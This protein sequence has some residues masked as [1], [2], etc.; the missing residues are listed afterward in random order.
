MREF[1]VRRPRAP[2][3]VLPKISF[4]PY[5][6]LEAVPWLML[7]SA[8]RFVAFG[9]PA[10]ALPCYILSNLAIF[11]AFL[12][13]ARRMIE[14]AEGATQLG[15]LAFNDQLRLGGKILGRVVLLLIGGAMVVAVTGPRELAIHMLIGFDGIAFD[16]FSKLGMLWS[17]FL[18][19][20]VLLMVLHAD[21]GGAVSFRQALSAFYRH[22]LY[23]VPAILLITAIAAG[24]SEVQGAL[25]GLVRTFDNTSTAPRQ[26]KNLV[27]F[28]FV[29]GFASLRLW[30][31]LAV[32][33]FALRESYR[34]TP[35]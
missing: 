13:A 4:G 24:V 27:Y 5:G 30:L 32:L 6:L 31:T 18:A 23:L 29:F 25:R 12:L 11:L 14:I 17:A 15:R 26:V 35:A 33:V 3:R 1:A 28:F 7:A 10:L 8:M 9:Q 19:T 21:E 22:G 16:Q 20:L 2:V 34:R